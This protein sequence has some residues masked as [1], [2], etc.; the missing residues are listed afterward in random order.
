MT[1]LKWARPLLICALVC[2]SGCGTR[3]I[4]I[5]PGDPVQLRQEVKGVDVWVFD[6]QGQR[7]EGKVDLPVG[8]YALPDMGE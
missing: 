3:T 1:A 6:A 5:K 2:L 7:I 4:L 8:W